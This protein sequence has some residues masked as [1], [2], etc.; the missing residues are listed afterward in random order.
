MAISESR[1][2]ENVVGFATP[3]GL[4]PR[5][6]WV[7]KVHDGLLKQVLRGKG[8]SWCLG[9]L[10]L[11]LLWAAPPA[12][13]AQLV[14]S[15]T[16]D[17]D[18]TGVKKNQ[19]ADTFNKLFS[20][21]NAKTGITMV[22]DAL[23]G[24]TEGRKRGVF[25]NVVYLEEM[26][27]R[28]KAKKTDI[29]LLSAEDYYL[30]PGMKDL[31]IPFA[32]WTVAGK[33]FGRE[34]LYASPKSGIK[35]AKDLKGKS[36][37]GLKDYFTVRHILFK[38]GVDAPL[39]NFFGRFD[40]QSNTELSV[41]AMMQGKLDTVLINHQL[42]FYLSSIKPAY[43]ALV[44]VACAE[45]MPLYMIM[46]R[47]GADMNMINKL[48]PLLWTAHRDPSFAPIKWFFLAFKGA[49]FKLDANYLASFKPVLA[50]G[51]AKGWA[52]ETMDWHKVQMPAL[53]KKYIST[54]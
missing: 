41:E 34:C 6:R 23:P 21:I 43:R 16:I 33:Q 22:L 15:V 10:A 35:T 26:V 24:Y 40:F 39:K 18:S 54:H 19:L 27:K 47:K 48:A 4:C 53:Y 12:Q 9:V 8:I 25:G 14:M 50:Q 29:V 3:R 31:V 30:W 49:F 1:N 51:Q 32:S 42:A 20:V 7:L 11:A 13:A 44:P 5:R 2:I 17:T 37:D 52:K 28:L 36:I 38:N 46:I 45:N